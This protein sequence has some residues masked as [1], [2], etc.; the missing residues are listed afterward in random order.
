LNKNLLSVAIALGAV[1]VI[2]NLWNLS[3]IEEN[4]KK[5]DVAIEEF[6]AKENI[7]GV[8][9][10]QVEEGKHAPDFK[11]TTLKGEPVKLSDYKG[12]KVILNFWATWCPPCKAEM[13]QMQ[14]FYE[15][16]KDNGINILAVNLTKME[17]GKA[18]IKK[19]ANDYHLTFKIA[20]DEEGTIGLQYQASTIP[21]S[22]IIDS[23]GVITKKIVGPMDEG[24]MEKLT[25]NIN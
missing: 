21:T 6:S 17:N 2:L 13:P 9:L 5:P 11:L 20:L 1:T 25:K 22:Y 10:S 24:M 16:E 4:K 8:D 14:N 3:K 23:N 19:F 18:A 15:R 7:P 12:K